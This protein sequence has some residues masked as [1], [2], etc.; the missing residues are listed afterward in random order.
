MSKPIRDVLSTMEAAL[1]RRPADYDA[2]IGAF[3]DLKV[4]AD[5][6]SSDL[7]RLFA[8]CYRLL[9]IEAGGS[10]ADLKSGMSEWQVSHLTACAHERIE[11]SM[12]DREASTRAWIAR[13]K[14][15]FQERGEPAPKGLGD[16]LPPRL[17]IPWDAE[18]ANARVRGYLAFYEGQLRE[19]PTC[20]FKLCWHALRDGY[21]VFQEVIDN[22]LQDL[23]A[24]RLGMPQ[25]AEIFPTALEL[26]DKAQAATEIPWAECENDVMPL[27]DHP[28]KMLAA[29]AA[30]YLGSLYGAGCFDEDQQA[31]KLVTM[32][33]TLRHHP[34]HRVAVCG[35]FVCGFDIM[36]EGLSALDSEDELTANGFD[37]DQWVIDVLA[38]EK[39]EDYLPNAQSFWF[40]VHE[41]YA[42][43]PEFAMRLI[44]VDR[45][46]IAMMCATEIDEEVVGMRPVLERLAADPDPQIATPAQRHLKEHY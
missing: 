1:A 46:W 36:V 2:L 25:T 17:N 20:H 5:V 9:N 23:A 15:R 12:Y 40:Y 45:A 35:G 18:T 44:E 32:L 30:R 11:K 16:Q 3:R 34:H 27:L 13:S 6:T 10:P 26:Y 22:W 39:H 42:A 29:G 38:A 24:R 4:P 8:A 33:E 19:Q 31:P 43:N 37:L 21:P 7:T 14:A 28:H 41:Y